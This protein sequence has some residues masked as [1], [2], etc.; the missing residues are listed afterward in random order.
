MKKKIAFVVAV[1]GTARS[2][3]KDHMTQLVQHY[4]VH[5][6][7]NFQMIRRKMSSYK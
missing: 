5:L 6:L 7:A 4:D 1:P 3:L 2:F